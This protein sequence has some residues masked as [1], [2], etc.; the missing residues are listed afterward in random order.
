MFNVIK[1]E[2]LTLLRDKGNIFFVI[3]FPSMM[4][5]LLGNLLQHMDNAD[6]TIEPFT[7]HIA[8]EAQDP[9]V[10]TAID[11]LLIALVENGSVDA[12]LHQDTT[13]SRI[14]VDTG[15]I[16]AAVVFTEDGEINVYEGH[17]KFQNR[18]VTSIFRGFARQVAGVRVL[19]AGD[20]GGQTISDLGGMA[21]DGEVPES[22]TELENQSSGS[23]DFP[24][25]VEKK[26]FGYNRSMLDYYA[27]T[28]IVM[29]LFMGGAIG[30]TSAMY[31]SRKDGT[32]RRV[33]AAP[34]NRVNL[35]VQNVLGTIPQNILQVGCVM[36]SSIFLFN[37]HYAD[38]LGDNLLL[39]LMLFAVGI[40][41]SS[42]SMVLGM[43]ITV[44]PTLLM[45][46]VVWVL[47][48]ISGTFS[49]EVF[50]D[51]VTPRLPTWIVQNAAF[52]LTVFG[53]PEKCL[54]ILL[55]SALIFILF[56]TVGALLF[57][58][59]GMVIK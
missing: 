52:D 38:T 11:E 44:N 21:R 28:M 45:M 41:V 39:F 42:L 50:I 32:L 51:G 23:R 17:D 35:Y 43:F 26:E 3:L 46:P 15:K 47:M 4:V 58:R 37:A 16:A 56:T 25:L 57:R 19:L 49:K 34:Q 14:L 53:R 6:M 22:Y 33:L 29:I 20:A 1:K 18:A 12:E 7:I 8:V 24:S 2:L 13:A 55:V 59:K 54:Q 9:L 30:G 31:E 5:F 36:L 40:A 10:H 48:F 27:V